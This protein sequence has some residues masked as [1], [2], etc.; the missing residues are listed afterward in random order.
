MAIEAKLFETGDAS[1]GG[2]GVSTQTS[3]PKRV[4]GNVVAIGV[5]YNGS[6][7][8]GTTDLTIRTKGRIGPA[9][10]ILVLTDTA[11]GGWF[12][13]AAP[14]VNSDASTPNYNDEA[15]EP[16]QRMGI[17]VHDDVEVVIAQANDNDGASVVLLVEV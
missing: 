2:A 5:T 1:T 17:P 14:V 8:A 4:E 13:L 9:R 6:P 16:V 7:P 3:A 15:D 10:N 11:T 12:D